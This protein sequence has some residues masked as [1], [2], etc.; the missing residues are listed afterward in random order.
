MKKKS[1]LLLL[2]AVLFLGGAAVPAAEVM[3][4]EETELTAEA[5]GGEET[6]SAAETMA[7][8]EPEIDAGAESGTEGA[9]WTDYQI[10]IAGEV[11]ALPMMYEE[12]VSYGWSLQDETE[13]TLEPYSYSFYSFQKDDMMVTAYVLNLG[14][15]TMP[16]EECIVAGISI[17][18]YYWSDLEE[19]VELPCGI[20]L[21]ESTL[22]DIEAAYGTPTD[23]YEGTQY[24]QYTYE[25]DYNQEIELQVFL[26]S[27]V[28]EDI[29]MENF[30]EPEGFDEGEM[31]TETP[32]SVLAYTKPESLSS[33]LS[34][35][36][37]EI[38]GDCYELPVPVSVLLED[39]W[40]IDADDSDSVIVAQYF[41]WVTLRKN[42]QSFSAIVTNDEDYATTPENC[43]LEELATGGYTLDMDGALPG[44]VRIGITEEEFLAILEEN[45]MEYEY[46]ESGDYHYYTYNSP[47]YGSSC[48]VTIY[49]GTDSYYEKDTIISVSCEHEL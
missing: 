37:I 13:D 1:L 25:E 38:D 8:E 40:E 4:G 47:S 11:Y 17:D 12:F 26:E 33:D 6:E 15:N 35:Y 28:L 36:E 19:T 49:A 20:V 34:A 44:G 21:G 39:G 24:T 3:A 7:E 2:G 43:W 31:S 46:T 32:Q 14:I 9:S 16:I 30:V 29:R 48:E 18:D 5:S 22:E 27:G 41:G 42:N 10:T 23:T 45:S